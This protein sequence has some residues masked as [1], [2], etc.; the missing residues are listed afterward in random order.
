MWHH[1]QPYTHPTHP[2]RRPTTNS[3]T[4]TTTIGTIVNE[5]KNDNDNNDNND[6]NDDYNGNDRVTISLIDTPGHVD[7]SVEVNRSVA[8]LDGAILVVDA[9]SGVQAQTETV[10]KAMTNP[11][12][13]NNHIASSSSSSL[14][15]SSSTSHDEVTTNQP[16]SRHH[17]QHSNHQHHHHHEPLPCL[18][19]INK[20]DKDGCHYMNAIRSI[21]HKLPGANPI[22]IQLPLFKKTSMSSSSSLDHKNHSNGIHILKDYFTIPWI[23]I[24]HDNNNNNNGKPSSCN[25]DWQHTGEFAGII[26]LIHMR[27]V[28]WP[29]TTSNALPEHCIPKIIPLEFDYNH[30]EEEV[31]D[32][33][34]NDNN[35]LSNMKN[36]TN[37]A[38]HGRWKLI[39]SLAECGDSIMEEY[40]LEEVHPSNMELRASVRRMTL[41]HSGIPVLAAAAVRG[42]GIEPVLDAIADYLPSPLDRQPPQLTYIASSSKTKHSNQKSKKQTNKKDMNEVE[43][44]DMQKKLGHSLHPS[45]LAFAFKVVHMKG[46]GGGGDGRVVF[47]R[48]Y[49]GAIHARDVVQVISPPPLGSAII[50]EETSMIR[51][52]RIGGMLELAGGRFDTLQHGECKS[53]GVCALVGLKSVVTGDTIVMYPSPNQSNKKIKQGHHHDDTTTTTTTTTDL[54]CLSGVASPNPVLKVRL[55]AEST[56]QQTRLAEALALLA[57]EDPSLLVEDTGSS[58]LL[59]GLGELHIEVTLDR[60]KR[61]YGLNVL[62]GKPSVAY[63]ETITETLETN[64]MYHFERMI[65]GTRLQASMHIILKPSV[66]DIIC[67]DDQ[68]ESSCLLLSEPTVSVSDTVKQFLG[69]DEDTSEEELMRKSELYRVL[70]AGCQGAMKRGLLGP[71]AMS[72]VH[73]HVVQIDSEHGLSGLISLPGSVRAAAVDTISSLLSHHRSNACCILEPNM[74]IEI[75]LPNDVVGVVLSDLASRRGRTREV[76]LGEMQQQSSSSSSKSYGSNHKALIRGEVPLIEI[77]GYANTIRSLTGGEGS[78]TAEYEGHAPCEQHKK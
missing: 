62:V 5:I 48:V 25:Y 69:F 60:L 78:F 37:M 45:L 31:A 34:D 43:K 42:K 57:I 11:S 36:I 58:T 7:F 77:L 30:Q 18:V 2:I 64:G 13:L 29:D 8:V 27:A 68:V 15:S 12:N 23:H 1:H 41:N 53:G 33:N 61:E 65:G 72:N 6:V 74:S 4:K 76:I 59:S 75:S 67:D 70:I 17:T 32:T 24:N 50:N 26:D 47:A 35:E 56:Q 38:I 71:Y 22:P 16:N 63:R 73:C 10:W 40:Y 55:E 49:S 51:K 66:N 54:V 19:V 14:S 44:M 9:V 3:K 46:R 52:E 20:M 39:E 21:Q 28:I